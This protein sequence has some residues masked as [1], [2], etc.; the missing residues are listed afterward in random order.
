MTD[1]LREMKEMVLDVSKRINGDEFFIG[2]ISKLETSMN[3]ICNEKNDIADDDMI[4]LE[5][6][7]NAL[8]G[9][10]HTTQND[11]HNYS[12]LLSTLQIKYTIPDDSVISK[13][14]IKNINKELDRFDKNV[15]LRYQ[16]IS[17]KKM[18]K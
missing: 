5:K 10:L 12:Q 1:R 11:I 18:E 13:K 9:I 2:L 7:L 16:D 3:L 4:T 15:L 14:N 17:N 8:I 6:N